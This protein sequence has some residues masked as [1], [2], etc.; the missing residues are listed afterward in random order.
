MAF[1]ERDS[2]RA[3]E[4]G[5]MTG[6][7][8]VRLTR[9][10]KETRTKIP[11]L[12]RRSGVADSTIRN[13]LVIPAD[14]KPSMPSAENAAD[15]AQA[16]DI[17]LQWLI[18]GRGEMRPAEVVA[19][20]KDQAAS[21]G[22]SGVSTGSG[23]WENFAM[24]PRLVVQASAGPG[25]LVEHEDAVDMIAFQ[26]SW[27]RKRGIN[28]QAA[29]AL[30]VRGDSMEPTIRSGDVLLVDTSKDRVEDN[31]IYVVVSA[32]YVLVKRVHPRRDG[33]LMLISDNQA[34][35]PEDVPAVEAND[36]HVA[37]R[38]MWFGRSI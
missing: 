22:F 4:F 24:V 16:L 7:F 3:S 32:G 25:A 9:A 33:S 14:K 28:P 1:K 10:L 31:G 13:W 20:F 35:P 18:A 30:T 23:E 27:L 37:G 36:F 29:R 38:V 26:E 19:I 8:A 2:D 34:Y 21:P 12:S 11:E 6:S 5:G 15:I 17:S